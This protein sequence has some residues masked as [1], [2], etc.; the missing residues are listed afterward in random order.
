MKKKKPK[1]LRV[2]LGGKAGEVVG[3]PLCDCYSCGLK[4]VALKSTTTGEHLGL[5]HMPI[6]AGEFGPNGETGCE[7]FDALS[8]DDMGAFADY[9][10]KC[11]EALEAKDRN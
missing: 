6:V 1:K 4:V 10:R 5:A 9:V 7:A 8:I 2:D 3:E 11:R